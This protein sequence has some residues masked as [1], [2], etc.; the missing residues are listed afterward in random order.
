MKLGFFGSS[1]LQ[2]IHYG[3]QSD[4]RA[5]SSSHRTLKQ[6]QPYKRGRTPPH[7]CSQPVALLPHDGKHGTRLQPPPQQTLVSSSQPHLWLS[8]WLELNTGGPP[9]T[10]PH[11]PGGLSVAHRTV[12]NCFVHANPSTFANGVSQSSQLS[13]AAL[14]INIRLHTHSSLK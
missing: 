10:L 9:S 1:D 14:W 4:S 6:P 12:P 7:R 5:K 13:C 2:T 11:Q 3:L 8:R